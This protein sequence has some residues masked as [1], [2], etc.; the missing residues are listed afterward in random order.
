M[1]NDELLLKLLGSVKLFAG[2]GRAELIELLA[3]A[4]KAEFVEGETVFVEGDEGQAVYVVVAGTAEVL[5]TGPDGLRTL[6]A[7]VLPGD[8]FGEMTLIDNKPRSA[9]VQAATDCLTLRLHKDKLE[10]N[11]AV[12]ARLY[13]NIARLLVRRLRKANDVILFQTSS[14]NRQRDTPIFG[15][16]TVFHRG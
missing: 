14:R 3:C 10:R 15:N 4:E 8:S 9:T 5:K 11:P 6:L 2:L 16:T 12:A 7:R 1:P 13:Q